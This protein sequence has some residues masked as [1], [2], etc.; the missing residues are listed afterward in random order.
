MVFFSSA[1]NNYFVAK[2]KGYASHQFPRSPDE[3]SHYPSS[4]LVYVGPS[5]VLE[6]VCP[7]VLATESS[8]TYSAQ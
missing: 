5:G 8:V 4:V 1:R 3:A 2:A 6:D 7:K